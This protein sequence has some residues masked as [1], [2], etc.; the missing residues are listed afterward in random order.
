MKD[1]DRLDFKNRFRSPVHSSNHEK[2]ASL[3]LG[4]QHHPKSNDQKKENA[5]ADKESNVS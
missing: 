3:G 4:G 2:L 1:H 5:A